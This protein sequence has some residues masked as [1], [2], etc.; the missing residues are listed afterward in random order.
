MLFSFLFDLYHKMVSIQNGTTQGGPLPPL[1]TPPQ[2]STH[3]W[4]KIP[5]ATSVRKTIFFNNGID[6][7][8][9]LN[10]F[11]VLQAFSVSYIF[12]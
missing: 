6:F 1:A 2:K 10:G 4:Q 12:Y 11:V 5:T 7:T 9:A 8:S 3:L